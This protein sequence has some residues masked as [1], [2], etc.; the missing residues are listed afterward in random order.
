MTQSKVTERG[1]RATT[2]HGERPDPSVARELTELARQLHAEHDPHALLD[3][4]VH[5][6]IADIDGAAHAGV[7]LLNK[8]HDVLETPAASDDLVRRIDEIQY[9]TRQGPCLQACFERQTVRSDDLR[10]EQRWPDFA[11][12]AVAAGV[13]SML[14]FEL[15]TDDREMGAL[16]LY[17]RHP[18]AFDKDAEEIGLLLAS[19][20]SI[21]LSTVRSESGLRQAIDS[22]DLIGQAKGILMER[23]KISSQQAFEMLVVASQRGHRKLRDVADHLAA[24]GEI[25]S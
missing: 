6:A 8:Q 18:N 13:V 23:Y 1:R 25:L 11:H 20:A 16:N 7:T 9:E 21:A 10:V 4:I 24:T 19:H 2:S 5:A 22:R 15:F 3:K 12:Q 17:A 14:A